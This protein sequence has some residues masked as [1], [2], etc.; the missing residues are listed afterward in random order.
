MY[1]ETGSIPCIV[2][3]KQP[4]LF[5]GPVWL[6][7]YMKSYIILFIVPHDSKIHPLCIF[8]Q[9]EFLL[10]FLEYVPWTVWFMAVVLKSGP[11]LVSV[12]FY[13]CLV[14]CFDFSHLNLQVEIQVYIWNFIHYLSCHH[15]NTITYI[16]I[17]LYCNYN[18]SVINIYV[19]SRFNLVKN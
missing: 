6:W 5:I 4:M 10:S 17:P 3:Y 18:W 7:W 8:F 13:G 1:S 14:D 9:S 16:W 19:W 15:Y 12:F 2:I 11:W